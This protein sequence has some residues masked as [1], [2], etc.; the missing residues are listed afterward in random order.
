MINRFLVFVPLFVIVTGIGVLFGIISAPVANAASPYDSVITPV[1]TLTLEQHGINENV[2]LTWRTILD[3][4][5]D[6]YADQLSSCIDNNLERG[7]GW[8]VSRWGHISDPSVSQ[9]YVWCTASSSPAYFVDPG[10]WDSST[11]VPA[12]IVPD[13]YECTIYLVDAGG[14]YGYSCGNL[15]PRAVAHQYMEGNGSIKQPYFINYPINYPPDYAGVE[16]SENGVPPP[17]DPE[18]EPSP[19]DI[20]E[21]CEVIDVVCHTRNIATFF[22]HIPELTAALF[23]PKGASIETT[24]NEL[25]D[26]FNEKFGFLIFPIDFI[27]RMLNAMMPTNP[28]GTYPSCVYNNGQY[29]VPALCSLQVGPILGEY[30]TIDFGFAEKNFPAFFNLARTALTGLISLGLILALHKKY[31]GVIKS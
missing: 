10:S 1:T 27:G 2:S 26:F 31:M 6:Y 30:M 15:F 12:L 17:V 8:G 9:V 23:V 13:I 25:R 7:Y 24:F 4:S 3:A 22:T 20:F 11:G 28:S 29:G 16:P 19:F 21:D 14:D 18:P 5:T